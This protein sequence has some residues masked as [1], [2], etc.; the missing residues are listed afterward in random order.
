MIAPASCEIVL[1]KTPHNGPLLS[2]FLK[3]LFKYSFGL[4]ISF[5]NIFSYLINLADKGLIVLLDF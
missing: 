2:P 4:I 1:A 3:T 5:E